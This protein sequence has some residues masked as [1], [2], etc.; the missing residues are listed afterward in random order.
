MS[1]Y[2]SSK[3]LREQRVIWLILNYPV[4]KHLPRPPANNV[5]GPEW[6]N[7]KRQHQRE[8]IEAMRADGVIAPSTGWMDVNLVSLIHKAYEWLRNGQNS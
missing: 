5:Y 3:D 6:Q 1:R 8:V 4:W 2:D 7:W